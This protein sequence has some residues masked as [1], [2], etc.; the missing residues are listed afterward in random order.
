MSED[1]RPWWPLMVPVWHPEYHQVEWQGEP[2]ACQFFGDRFASYFAAVFVQDQRGN[3][4]TINVEWAVWAVETDQDGRLY[5]DAHR[6]RRDSKDPQADWR[7]AQPMT[8]GYVKWDGCTQ[9]WSDDQPDHHDGFK[10]MDA[11][12]EAVRWCREVAVEHGCQE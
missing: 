5:C 8:H 3:H 11:W 7:N 6:N 1:D 9:W 12:F 2:T 4:G 10:S